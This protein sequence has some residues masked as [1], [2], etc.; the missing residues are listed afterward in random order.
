MKKL[1]VWVYSLFLVFGVVGVANAIC[2]TDT[3]AL[4][5]T[6][7][8]GCWAEN[9]WSDSISYEHSTPDD[10]DVPPDDVISA[11][12][13]I[14]GYWINDDNDYVYVEET[15][16]GHL[17]AGGSQFFWLWDSPSYSVFNIENT[18]SSWTAGSKLPITIE[19]NGDAGDGILHLASS[20][21]S[22]EYNNN[23][24]PAPVPEP[25]TLVLIGTGLIV[26]GAFSVKKKY[27]TNRK[28]I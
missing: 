6:L 10:F 9:F 11:T 4:N 2:F 24:T 12:L 14:S 3:I 19:A 18:F 17:N 16:T 21:F 13:T 20:T 25:G 5:A 27:R 7:G 22:L 1:G 8:E 26:L 28:T 15:K 23:D